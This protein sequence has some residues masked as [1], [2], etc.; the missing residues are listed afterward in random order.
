MRLA[1]TRLTLYKREVRDEVEKKL[2]L[3]ETQED[4]AVIP[5]LYGGVQ[6]QIVGGGWEEGHH[7]QEVRDQPGEQE[8]SLGEEEAEEKEDV[9]H[10]TDGVGGESDL[11]KDVCRHHGEAR[12][13]VM[14]VEAED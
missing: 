14:A 9:G 7:Q 5:A 12:P 1:V 6:H 3:P 10:Q 8:E 11:V 2:T 4:G 13:E